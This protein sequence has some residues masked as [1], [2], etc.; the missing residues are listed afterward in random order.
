[1][2]RVLQRKQHLHQIPDGYTPFLKML[3]Y[4]NYHGAQPTTQLSKT[5]SVIHQCIYSF[6]CSLIS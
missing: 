5:I 2:L 4:F 3:G 6:V 1:M